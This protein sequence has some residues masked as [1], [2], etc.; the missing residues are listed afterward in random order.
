MDK[1]GQV[2][3]EFFLYAGVFLLV[4]I[5]SFAIV[6]SV[7]GSEIQFRESI[8]SKEAGNSFADTVNLAI[9]SGEGFHYN[10]TFRKTLLSRQYEVFFDD[11]NGRLF[12][13]WPGTYGNITNFYTIATYD[14]RFS[15]C[16][17]GKTITS[18]RCKNILALYN[19]GSTLFVEQPA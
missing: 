6:S 18:S 13:I 15:G 7:Q 9:R 1:K 2:A 19:N 8:L 4:I 12:F 3:T 5:F 17:S 11:A 16:A 10:L 14:Y